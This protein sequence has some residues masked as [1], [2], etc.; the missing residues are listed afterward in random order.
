MTEVV[1]VRGSSCYTTW[2]SARWSRHGVQG[3]AAVRTSTT[4]FFIS[5]SSLPEYEKKVSLGGAHRGPNVRPSF[6]RRG[7]QGAAEAAASDGRMFDPRATHSGE[8]P[9]P[10]AVAS[11]ISGVFCAVHAASRASCE[12]KV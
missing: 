2:D 12:Q 6:Q 9:S 11:T 10:L 7:R 5:S 8:K 3:G 4:I 1:R